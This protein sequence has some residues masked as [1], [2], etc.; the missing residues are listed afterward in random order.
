MSI[1]NNSVNDIAFDFIRNV[2][3]FTATAQP[4]YKQHSIGYGLGTINGVPVKAGDVITRTQADEELKTQISNLSRYVTFLTHQPLSNNQLAAL[5]SFTYNVG[6]TAFSGSTM[7]K[8][9]NAGE[10]KQTVAMQFDKW[11][12]AGGKVNQGLVNRRN[13]EKTLFLS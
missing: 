10:N 1:L 8:Q 7:L 5:I 13:K 12:Y 2:E 3:G 9:I 11:I 6:K 4:D